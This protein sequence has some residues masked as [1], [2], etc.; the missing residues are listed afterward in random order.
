MAFEAIERISQAEE[1]ARRDCAQAMADAKAWEAAAVEAGKAAMDEAAVRARKEIQAK[2]AQL[3]ADAAVAAEV[4]AGETEKQKAAMR[5]C[6]EQKLEAAATL[7]V[8]RI[9]NG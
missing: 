1:T 3:E 4:L 6:A 2:Q 9:V 8:E 5:A 7:I